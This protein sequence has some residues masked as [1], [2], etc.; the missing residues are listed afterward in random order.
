MTT[1]GHATTKAKQHLEGI[2]LPDLI[3]HRI[4][5]E[6]LLNNLGELRYA[7]PQASIDLVSLRDQPGRRRWKPDR[8][9]HDKCFL[10]RVAHSGTLYACSSRSRAC[11]CRVDNASMSLGLGF[12]NPLET[13]PSQRPNM[14]A[15]IRKLAKR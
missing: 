10:G 8:Y 11:E 13:L 7:N 9:D 4:C 3:A 14:R 15:K 1:K 12:K 6:F 5:G 2:E